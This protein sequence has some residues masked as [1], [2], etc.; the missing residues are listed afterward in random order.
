MFLRAVVSVA[1]AL[2]A[3][4]AIDPAR[5]AQ[6]PSK[7]LLADATDLGYRAVVLDPVRDAKSQDWRSGLLD[8]GLG[9]SP[10]ERLER[11][12]SQAH[13]LAPSPGAARYAL[14]VDIREQAAAFALRERSTGVLVAEHTTAGAEFGDFR[15]SDAL[16]RAF[17]AF[18][19]K[20]EPARIVRI[21]D[22]V[23]CVDLNPDG[24]GSAY[25]VSTATAV[26]T[27]CPR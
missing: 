21:R 25:L 22:G 17:A 13:L 10:R 18:A 20:L 24:V 4:S 15:S 9:A 27:D 8:L 16:Q 11:W 14:T 12:L 2:V 19:E 26:A 5:A 3:V 1:L 23:R 7:V 6:P